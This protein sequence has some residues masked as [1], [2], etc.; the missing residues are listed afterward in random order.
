[1]GFEEGCDNFSFPLRVTYEDL[2]DLLDSH[3]QKWEK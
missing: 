3:G 2:I 1:M